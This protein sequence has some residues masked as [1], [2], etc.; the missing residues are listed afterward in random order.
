M[1]SLRRKLN[2]QKKLNKA[3]VDSVIKSLTG[4]IKNDYNLDE[5]KKLF[6]SKV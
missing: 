4:I 5:E 2:L 6:E 3:E 1:V